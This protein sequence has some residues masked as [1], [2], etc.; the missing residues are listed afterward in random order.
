MTYSKDFRAKVLSIRAKEGLSFSQVAKR[1]GVSVNSIFLWSKRLEPKRSK[2]RP[3][4]KIDREILMED[5]RKYPDAYNYERANRLKV[6]TSGIC[7]AIKKLGITYKKNVQSS[8]GLRRKA[9]NI[10]L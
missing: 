3:A 7:Y 5:I 10:L 4:I 6:S 9:K 8:K 2:N 1:F